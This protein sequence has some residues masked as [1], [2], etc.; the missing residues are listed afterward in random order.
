LDFFYF[1]LLIINVLVGCGGGGGGGGKDVDEPFSGDSGTG[2]DNVTIFWQYYGGI[3]GGTSV[4]QTADGGF[5]FAGE[6]GSDF[7]F[8][9]K[10]VFLAKA[11]S[12]GVLAWSR[13][14]GSDG[15]QSPQDV[16]QCTDGGYI[17][18]GYTDSGN[19]RDVHVVRTDSL[20]NIL[21]SRTY[22][23]Q[24]GDDEGYAICVLPNGYALAGSVTRDSGS[25]FMGMDAWFFQI[26]ENGV[27]IPG[28]DRFYPP[29]VPGWTK[30]YD[31]EKTRDNG[32]ILTGRG[33][34]NAVSV[35]KLS[36]DGTVIWSNGFGTGVGYSVKQAAAPDNGFLVAGSTTPFDGQESDVLV[37]KLDASGKEQWRKVFGGPG[38]DVGRGV[39]LSSDGGYLVAG[40]TES[41]SQSDFVYLRDDVYLIKL[42]ANGNTKWQKVKGQAPDNSESASA[43]QAT[44]DGGYVI[45]GSS[46]AQVMLSKFDKNGDTVTLGELDF[47]FLVPDAIGLISLIN[48]RQIGETA[49]TALLTP[50]RIGSTLLNLF[51]NTIKGVPPSDF[52]DNGG[53]YSWSPSLT[54]PV[55]EG[56][57]HYFAFSDCSNSG[58]ESLLEGAVR[59]T[60]QSLTGNLTSNAY[61]ITLILDQVD[62][63]S[64]DDAGN[65]RITGELLFSR[66]NTSG[67]FSQRTAKA[68]AALALLE[69]GLTES[70]SQFD[71]S[72]TLSDGGGA[73]SIG[74]P[75]QYVIVDPGY[76][77][78]ALNITVQQTISGSNENGP[79]QGK[80]L[81]QAQDGSRLTL[82][83]TDGNVNLEVDTNGDGTVDGTISTTWE[84]LN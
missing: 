62:I 23:A 3:G 76:L 38:M 34:P 53:G 22:D 56:N 65:T 14:F 12:Q 7:D 8:A 49:I 50:D 73:F 6:Q 35:M 72:S 27:K 17:T 74:N 60:I 75:N 24:G 11:D 30:A 55:A 48:A 31:M 9:T 1:S 40:V 47:T 68:G 42:A 66:I 82:I 26:D 25:G 33:E 51:I 81:V 32:F 13:T 54:M 20:G 46:Q 70:I 39:A 71:I 45:T 83:F 21:W 80:V 36:E 63:T 2:A 61:D 28:S 84:D 19:S 64:T 37:I 58:F 29:P 10:N 4:L 16:K 52:C 41:F 77:A 79:D 5:I 15:G 59:L 44:V 78:G 67:N 57:T 69:A 43:I 18:A